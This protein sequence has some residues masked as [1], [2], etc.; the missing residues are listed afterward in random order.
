MPSRPSCYGEQP[1]PTRD[2]FERMD[3][4]ARRCDVVEMQD[5]DRARSGRFDPRHLQAILSDLRSEHSHQFLTLTHPDAPRIDE[6][7]A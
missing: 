1:A 6:S 5:P 7:A 2:C 3:T 4:E